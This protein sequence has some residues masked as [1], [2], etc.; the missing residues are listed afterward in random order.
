M[1]FTVACRRHLRPALPQKNLA[2]R[3]RSVVRRAVRLEADNLRTSSDSDV[4][5]TPESG[6]SLSPLGCLLCAK[7]GHMQCSKFPY[8]AFQR[9]TTFH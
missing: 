9:Q 6:H 2:R 4:R 5:F 8:R 1:E 7:S 3:Q